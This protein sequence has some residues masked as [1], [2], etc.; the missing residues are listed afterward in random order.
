M[1]TIIVVGQAK[2][3]YV[4]QQVNKEFEGKILT[5]TRPDGAVI[6]HNLEHGVRP[7]CYIDAGADISVCNNPVDGELELF[8]TTED[9]Q[10]LTVTFTEIIAMQGVPNDK[11]KNNSMA[12][13]ILR[14]IFDMESKYGRTTIAKVLMGSVSKKVLTI[15]LEK[16]TMYGSCKGSS[17][18]EVLGLIDWLI[19]ENYIAYADE[20]CLFPVLTITKKGLDILAGPEELPVEKTEATIKEYKEPQKLD[21]PCPDC[22]GT[23][24]EITQGIIAE[25][26]NDCKKCKGT[27]VKP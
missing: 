19:E 9:G 18:K 4:N 26:T 1:T 22:K 16:L 15:S 12:M 14:C 2:G 17:M 21:E 24:D 7:M 8:A 23:G 3:T 6:V 27:G 20:E 5:T 10:Q 13:N 11:K 25:F